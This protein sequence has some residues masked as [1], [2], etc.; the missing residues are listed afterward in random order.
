MLHH[1]NLGSGLLAEFQAHGE[2]LVTLVCLWT[3]GE[4]TWE[5]EKLM[6]ASAA[7]AFVLLG[8]HGFDQDAYLRYMADPASPRPP[9]AITKARIIFGNSLDRFGG[10]P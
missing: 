8:E 4:K 7:S 5:E 9:A 6:P 1:L 2:P 10:S 3:D